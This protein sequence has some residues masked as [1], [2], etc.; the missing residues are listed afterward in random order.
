M[1]PRDVRKRKARLDAQDEPLAAPSPRGSLSDILPDATWDDFMEA[2]RIWEPRMS[3][4]LPD[5]DDAR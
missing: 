2:K 4:F 1:P 5:E 3:H